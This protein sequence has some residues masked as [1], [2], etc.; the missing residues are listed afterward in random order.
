[1]KKRIAIILL[2]MLLVVGVCN[3]SAENA[4]H[5]QNVVFQE[6][7]TVDLIVAVPRAENLQPT[8]FTVVANKEVIAA[9]SVASLGRSDIATRWVFVIDLSMNYDIFEKAKSALVEL[10]NLLPEKDMAAVITTKMTTSELQWTNNKEELKAQA[11]LKRD[12]SATALNAAVADAVV[13]LEN[14]STTFERTCVVIMSN[15]ENSDVAGMT[16][17]E[18]VTTIANSHVAVYTYAFKDEEPNTSKISNFGAYA[19]ASAGGAEIIVERRELDALANAKKVEQNEQHF[20][21][22]KLSNA[23]LPQEI[24]SFTVSLQD[25]TLLLTDDF[26][27]STVR[28]L[29]YA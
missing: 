21:I 19:R 5:L 26:Q 6:D 7:G 11:N 14:H 15:G 13:M 22:V 12:Y 8:D 23:G 24:S 4:L 18:L 10:I 20:R 2:M 9:E 27:L 29:A 25:G 16:Q 1:M 3:A 28:Q 17:N